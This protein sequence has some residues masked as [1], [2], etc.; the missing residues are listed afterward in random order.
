MDTEV[1]EIAGFAGVLGQESSSRKVTSFPPQ[2]YGAFGVKCIKC[3][4]RIRD[5]KSEG[6]IPG[7][8]GIAKDWGHTEFLIPTYTFETTYQNVD[9]GPKQGT[10]LLIEDYK[11]LGMDLGRSLARTY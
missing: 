9:Y 7:E 2:D 4:T 11:K 1:V 10:Y 6:I 5:Q 3:N 8:T